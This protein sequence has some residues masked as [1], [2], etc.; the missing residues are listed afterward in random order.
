[1]TDNKI[2][3][4]A[5]E[6]SDAQLGPSGSND[7]VNLRQEIQVPVQY[8]PQEPFLN[9]TPAASPIVANYRVPPNKNFKLPQFWKQMLKDGLHHGSN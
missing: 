5:S 8:E 2:F 3:Q 6:H 7:N 1:M 4:N 9:L